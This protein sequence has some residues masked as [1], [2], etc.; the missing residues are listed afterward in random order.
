ML[1]LTKSMMAKQSKGSYHFSIKH[2]GQLAFN[3]QY[4]TMYH[5]NN[6]LNMSNQLTYTKLLRHLYKIC[7]KG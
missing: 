5:I 1:L 3:V 7:Y 4:K 6:A 2:K